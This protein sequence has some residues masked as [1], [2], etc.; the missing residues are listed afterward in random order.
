MAHPGF[1][2]DNQGRGYPF[3][4]GVTGIAAPGVN[5]GGLQ[6]LPLPTI[7]DFG[8]LMGL[9]SQYQEDQHLVYLYR[10]KRIGNELFFEFR[11]N[12]P[13][14]AG[15][16]L[17]FCRYINDAVYSNQHMGGVKTP[18]TDHGLIYPSSL[19]VTDVEIKE[20]SSFDDDDCPNDPLW[21]GFLVTGDLSYLANLLTDGNSL[22]ATDTSISVE[23]TL[24]RS[25][26]SG[27]VRSINIGNTDRT[28]VHSPPGCKDVL[29]DHQIGITF[30]QAQCITGQVRVQ[31]G[32]NTVIRQNNNDNSLT[33]GAQ[34]GAG[35]G[36]PCIE[37]PLF[38][39]EKPQVGGKLLTGGP[40]CS[41]VLRTINGIGTNGVLNLIPG[42]GTTIT[43]DPAHSKLVI[44]VDLHN[45]NV[46]I[47]Q[48]AHSEH[49]CHSVTTADPTG[50]G[51]V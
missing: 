17:V 16:S 4:A 15:M 39:G 1:L 36:E 42:P 49:S 26:V 41:E 8:C 34:V 35:A 9:Y 10:V 23:P 33:L 25:L 28:R 5:P 47:V 37:V 51:P 46:C 14:L 19:S 48:S 7:V 40:L 32:F 24:V 21:V 31:E 13:G 6:Y 29:W 38:D 43:P 50:C 44:D 20:E 45:L 11:S 27:Y 22:V 2:N 3:L 12:A 30:T 18:V